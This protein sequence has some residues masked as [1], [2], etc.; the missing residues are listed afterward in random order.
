MLRGRSKILVRLEAAFVVGW[1]A[2]ACGPVWA[3]TLF[4]LAGPA[5]VA[6]GG[7]LLVKNRDWRPVQTQRVKVEIPQTGHPF[8]GLFADGGGTSGLKAGVNAAGLTVVTATAGS[9]PR[10]DRRGE[11]GMVGILRK[12]LTQCASVAEAVSR[13]DLFGR[14]RPCMFLLSDR[15][16]VARVEV[17]PGGRYAVSRTTD[18]TLWQTNHYLEPALGD[19]NRR[20]GASSQAR[21]GRIGTLLGS[22]SKPARL[23]ALLALSRDTADGPDNGIWRTGGTPRA[24]RTLATFAVAMPPVGPG[25]LFVRLADPGAPE[26]TFAIPL[27]AAAFGRSRPIS[28]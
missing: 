26:R 17:R 10:E 5:E 14:G 6:G 21:A 2:V 16:A 1:L 13:A 27:D 28:R 15:H 20:I 24:V 7:T 25:R 4:G 3:C 8:I 18:G 19:G 22:L 9:L 23:D 12:L 11:V